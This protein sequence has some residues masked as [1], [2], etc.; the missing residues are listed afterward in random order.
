MKAE[1]LPAHIVAKFMN[2][3]TIEQCVKEDVQELMTK[4]TFAILK[5]VIRDFTTLKL[6]SLTVEIILEKN[7]ISA[8]S[9]YLTQAHT[10]EYCDKNQMINVS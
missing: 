2:I 4:L 8:M 6:W 9:I 7:H 10:C 5:V 3:F 1:S